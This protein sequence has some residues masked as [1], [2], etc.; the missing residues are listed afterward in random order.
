MKKCGYH[1]VITPDGQTLTQC[2]VVFDRHGNPVQWYPFTHE[3]PFVEWLGGMLDLRNTFS[4]RQI[5]IS[6]TTKF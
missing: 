1:H 2:I 5:N 6:P 3:E 4:H